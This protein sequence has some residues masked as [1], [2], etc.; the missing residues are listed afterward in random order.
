MLIPCP[1]CG[2]R[3]LAEFTYVGDATIR[4]PEDGAPEAAWCDYLYAR[5]NPAGRHLE[6]WHHEGGCRRVLVVDRDT[7]THEVFDAR[8]AGEPAPAAARPARAEPAP[9]PE[10]AE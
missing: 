7:R 3:D 5:R 4:R 6:H 8:L 2:S 10:P 1:H 9:V